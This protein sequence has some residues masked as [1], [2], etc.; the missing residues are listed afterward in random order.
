MNKAVQTIDLRGFNDYFVIHFG[1][2][3]HEIS[4][5]TLANS[6]LGLSN[7]VKIIDSVFNH[8]SR[9]DFIIESTGEGSF[10]VVAKSVRVGLSNLFTLENAKGIALGLLCSAIWY[11]MGPKDKVQITVNTNEYIV[12]SGGEKIILP[13]EAKEYFDSIR[14][15][16]KIKEEI[17]KTFSVLEKD[18]A[19]DIISFYNS[20]HDGK[21][22]ISVPRNSFDFL[23]R[24][25]EVDIEEDS[26]EMDVTLVIIKAV[27]KN[28]L[29][30]W[31]FILN[32]K[33]ISAPIL[34]NDFYTDFIEHKVMIA[35]GDTLDARIRV[36]RQKDPEF[37]VL[38][39]KEYEILYVYKHN[40]ARK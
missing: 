37:G 2:A 16:T 40:S 32:G 22:E 4:V 11:Y 33:K 35:P 20:D 15:N 5:D 27:L 21:P 7:S 23:S 25:N 29:Q 18:K 39:D 14:N 13:R 10:K 36:I 26:Y 3:N 9:I 30:K 38:V 31:Q 12:E 34:H 1:V 8:G 17:S 19:I 24:I 6:L 28:C